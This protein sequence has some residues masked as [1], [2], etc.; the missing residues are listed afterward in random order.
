MEE[1]IDKLLKGFYDFKKSMEANFDGVNSRLDKLESRMDKLESRMDKLE[2][3]MDKL[4]G[5]MDKLEKKMDKG[6][7][8]VHT[9]I[10]ELNLTQR[11]IL[12]SIDLVNE[13][14]KNNR[15]HITA[16]EE[17]EKYV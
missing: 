10:Y 6:F 15:R 12:N 11:K 4:E 14:I 3:R 2:S 8:E 5:R 1:K 17:K 7:E 16:L 13:D 9:A